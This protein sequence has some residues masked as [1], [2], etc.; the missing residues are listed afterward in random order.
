M[1]AL[2]FFR[3]LNRMCRFYKGCDGC[4][5][6]DEECCP[7]IIGEKADE[8]VQFVERWSKD[9][10]KKTRVQDEE[11][12]DVAP[13][14]HARWIDIYESFETA[15]CSRCHSQFEVTFNGEANG[16][17]WD[18]FNQ[19]YNYCPNCGAKMDLEED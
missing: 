6:C 8:I 13:V 3:E 5:F 10:P 1:D 9:H 12:A 14:A 4:P 7:T 2:M 19:F 17:L 16:A 15:E 18:G 11:S